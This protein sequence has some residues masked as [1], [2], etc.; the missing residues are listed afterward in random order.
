ML[1]KNETIADGGQAPPAPN[2]AAVEKLWSSALGSLN[3]N[4]ECGH[5]QHEVLVISI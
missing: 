2:A 4:I 5:F 1:S 3:P